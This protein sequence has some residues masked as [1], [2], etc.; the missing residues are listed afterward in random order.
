M[1]HLNQFHELK[2][3]QN[4]VLKYKAFTLYTFPRKLKSIFYYLIC[5]LIIDIFI[6]N[7]HIQYHYE[8]LNLKMI[9]VRQFK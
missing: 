2:L 5:N 7:Y 6:S 9:L 1:V 3:K 4:F 8:F